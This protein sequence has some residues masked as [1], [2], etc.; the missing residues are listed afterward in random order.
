MFQAQ[1][2]SK[3]A[4]LK[5]LIRTNSNVGFWICGAIDLLAGSMRKAHVHTAAKQPILQSAVPG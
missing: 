3:K 4:H 1:N 5:V 2:I